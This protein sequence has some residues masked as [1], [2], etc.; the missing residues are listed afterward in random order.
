MGQN[1]WFGSDHHLH[2][3]KLVEGWGNSDKN[4]HQNSTARPFATIEEHDQALIDNHNKVVK[5][6]D[7]VWFGGDV[8]L[9][10]GPGTEFNY[11]L[12]GKMNGDKRLIVGNH[13]TAA[14]IKNYA[15]YF[16][17]IVG[18]H[19]LMK[20]KIIVSHIPVHPSQIEHR[21]KANI[22]GHVHEDTL[23][24]PRYFNMC[25]ENINYTPISL[26]EIVENL[27]SK[28]VL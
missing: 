13:D 17:K 15:P 7:V 10:G 14:K 24:D 6:N 21:F 5:P 1:T 20:L 19:E 18:Y 23:D 27:K 28:G 3:R 16:S 8:M 2:H 25:M 11:E 12:L 4:E 9:S 22:H 26:E